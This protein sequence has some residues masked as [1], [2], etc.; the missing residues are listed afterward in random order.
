M[1]RIRYDEKS[2]INIVN[3]FNDSGLNVTDF[4][5]REGIS[6][7]TFSD[8]VKKYNKQENTIERH[9]HIQFDKR[10]SNKLNVL[11]ELA[12]LAKISEKS[13]KI[14]KD[15]AEIKIKTDKP[16]A[17]MKGADFHLGGLDVSY[18][19]LLD[20]YKFLLQE[21]G[22]YM[23]L[24]GDDINM[25]IVH[26]T[27]GARHDILSP[28]KQCELIS[29]MVDDLVDKHKLI[30]MCWGNHSDEFAERTLGLSL[31]KLLVS[32][33]IPYFRGVGYINLTVGIHTYPMAFTHKMRFNSFMNQLHGNKRMEQMHFEFFGPS[34]PIAR[35]YI[36]AHTHYPSYSV[37]GNLPNERVW[38]IKVGTFKND[39][40]YSQR[41][42]GQGKIG[43]PTV[44]YFPDKFE[45]ICFPTP[46][47]A[48]RYMTGKN[49]G[50]LKNSEKK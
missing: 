14:N 47:E 17:I 44:V 4:S 16:I 7:S 8:W 5:I 37:E 2:K 35:E 1:T 38:Y 43:V 22:F 32:N 6:R 19:A 36:T 42:Y 28:N 21:E 10:S 46:Y 23:Q 15:Y 39:C 20:H 24:F 12:N 25:M 30:S 27:V 48:Y 41:Y 11:E 40:L 9:P 26:K 50:G 34:K 29:S 18:D 13:N 33:K 3:K 49:W 31:M 45:H